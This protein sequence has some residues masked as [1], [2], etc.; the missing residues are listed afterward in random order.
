MAADDAR[1][2]A[3][4]EARESLWPRMAGLAVAFLLLCVAG[5]ITVWVPELR[6]DPGPGADDAAPAGPG[7]DAYEAARAADDA[8]GDAPRSD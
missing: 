1:D 4:G 6:N 5:V 8:A 3:G 7:S 2:A